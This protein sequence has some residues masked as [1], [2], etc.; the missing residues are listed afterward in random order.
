MRRRRRSL[1]NTIA[2]EL[3]VSR[4]TGVPNDYDYVC[5]DPVNGW[6]LEGTFCLTG[7]LTVTELGPDARGRPT[8]R[9]YTR[10]RSLWEAARRVAH[11]AT[12]VGRWGRCVVGQ[13]NGLPTKGSASVD[14]GI[15]LAVAGRM[16]VQMG[17]A[18]ALAVGTGN[19]IIGTAFV[20]LGAYLIYR[21]CAR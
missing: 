11:V 7:T 21:A 12:V 16:A 13:L 9:T 2:A 3:S 1:L 14:A 20:G 10:C 18:A 19:I 17:G 8:V 4:G 6:D 5:A 15:A